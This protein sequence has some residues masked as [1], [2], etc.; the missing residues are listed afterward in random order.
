MSWDSREY[1]RQR[2]AFIDDR[3]RR[4]PMLTATTLILVVTWFVGWGCSALLLGF[5]HVTSMPARYALSFAGAYAAFFLCVPI[6]CNSVRHDQFGGGGGWSGGDIGGD[7]EGCLYVVAI[8]LAAFV[9][10]GLFWASGGFAALLEA[11]FEVTFA[12]TVVRR[13]SH[14]EIVGHWARALFLNSWMQALA[15][16]V[17]LVGIAAALQR[18]A[19][20]A[21][22]FAQAIERLWAQR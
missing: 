9:V 21:H 15:A 11:A 22:T 14:T 12:G 16:L 10:A 4:H 6:W 2:R 7:P 20:G 17:M 19:P 18:S 3:R 1:L 5:G 13:L 8:G